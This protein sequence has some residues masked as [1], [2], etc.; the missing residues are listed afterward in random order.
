MAVNKEKRKLIL[1]RLGAFFLIVL[2][3]IGAWFLV[4]YEI[5]RSRDAQALARIIEIQSVLAS[6]AAR[7]GVYPSMGENSRILGGQGAECLSSDGFVSAN[8]DSC[9]LKTFGLFGIL[10]GIGISQIATYSS[11]G[12][13]MVTPCTESNG[14][15][16]YKI[17]F[18][19]ETNSIAPKGLH[20]VSPKG[21]N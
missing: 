2:S 14:C 11:V 12:A 18:F 13:D 16:F 1:Q 6:Y 5:A 8:S 4:R 10:P 3:A 19:L 21:L 15:P 17:E 20:S 7:H 9:R